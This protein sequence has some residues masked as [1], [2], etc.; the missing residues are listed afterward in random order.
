[1]SSLA[2]SYVLC[3]YPGNYHVKTLPVNLLSLCQSLVRW[4]SPSVE[5]LI[6][7]PK[8]CKQYA[9]VFNSAFLTIKD[10]AADPSAYRKMVDGRLPC[11]L[12]KGV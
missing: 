2:R 7:D 6:V 1:M 5:V 9:I 3:F 11:Q 8:T 4:V 10:L 12:S